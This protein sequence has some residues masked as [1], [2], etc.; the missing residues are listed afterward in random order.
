MLR[1]EAELPVAF[2]DRIRQRFPIYRG[3][4]SAG[5]LGGIAVPDEIMQVVRSNFPGVLQKQPRAFSSADEKWT[6]T[7]AKDALALATSDYSRWETFREHLNSAVQALEEVYE[8]AFYSR[9]GLRYRDVIRRSALGLQAQG[10]EDLLRHDLAGEVIAPEIS[11]FIEKTSCQTL[12]RLPN[13]DSRVQIRHGLSEEQGEPCYV[14]DSDFF[15]QNRTERSDVFATLQ[16][17]NTQAHRLFRWCISDRLHD[18]MGP[19]LLS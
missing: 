11:A 2:Q 14:I 10:W 15:T 13:F 6:V 16:Y 19:Q 7:M 12:V 3:D 5:V 9:I 4:E 18:A 8:P 17:F 1:I